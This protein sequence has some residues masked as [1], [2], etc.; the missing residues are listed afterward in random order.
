M[1]TITETTCV[2]GNGSNYSTSVAWL[3]V[4]VC[5]LIKQVSQMFERIV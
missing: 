2:I 5:M 3:N 4:H 1:A